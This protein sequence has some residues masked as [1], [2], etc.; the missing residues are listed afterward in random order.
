M[1]LVGFRR[2]LQPPGEPKSRW[3]RAFLFLLDGRPSFGVSAQYERRRFFAFDPPGV[4]DDLG[5]EGGSG[6]QGGRSRVS[7]SSHGSGSP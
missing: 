5:R 1:R 3:E 2:P 6:L 4:F 7:S